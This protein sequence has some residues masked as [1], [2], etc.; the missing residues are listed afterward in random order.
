VDLPFE[1][2]DGAPGTTEDASSRRVLIVDDETVVLDVLA[3]VL[4]KE[5]GLKLT[6]VETAEAAIELMQF[7]RFDALVTDKNLPGMGGIELIESARRRWPS[8]EAVVITG[9]ASAE[10]VIAALAAG[11]SDYLL[12]PFDD[13]RVVRGK[14]LAA[15]ERRA[16]RVQNREAARTTAR[17]AAE[18][19]RRGQ[20]APEPVWKEL[21]ARF[22]EYESAIRE[23][24]LGKVSV[25]SDP[26]AARALRAAGIDAQVVDAGAD[27]GEAEVV[28]LQTGGPSWHE[29]AARLKASPSDVVLLS[30]PDTE[31]PDLLEALNL[32]LE[33]AAAIGESPKVLVD[34]VRSALL[35]RAVERAQA[36][37]AGA[38]AEFQGQL[39]A[40]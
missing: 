32:R 8:I 25:E 9:Y 33:L 7:E 29:R 26:E 21:E 16:A 17:I 20:D 23:S 19:L 30:G 6:C 13:I 22:L 3:R 10:S 28:V 2:D 38:L 11:A 24:P 4:A 12:K 37:L 35:R 15:L 40:R 14:I 39:R 27:T 18:L 36:K 31:L 34:R 5:P 1:V